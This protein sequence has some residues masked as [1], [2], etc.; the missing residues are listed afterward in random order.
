MGTDGKPNRP[1]TDESAVWSGLL[2]MS[3]VLI[4]G[5]CSSGAGG[6]LDSVARSGPRCRDGAPP[7]ADHYREC[8]LCRLASSSPK[9]ALLERYR[10]S[11]A[12]EHSS[13]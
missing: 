5:V 2:V 3:F 9:C 1:A 8:P 4:V 10:R 7:D 12:S 6:A 11:A 13:S